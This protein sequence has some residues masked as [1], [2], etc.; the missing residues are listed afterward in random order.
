[1]LKTLGKYHKGEVNCYTCDTCGR[2]TKTRDADDGVTP[3][4]IECPFCHG[5][6]MSS[7]YQDIAPDIPVTHEF[8]RPTLEETLAMV[9]G[10]FFTVNHILT[11]GLIRRSCDGV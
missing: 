3:M 11:E 7:F 9:D 4:G 8:Y 1:M 10:R 2:V 6:A 5:D